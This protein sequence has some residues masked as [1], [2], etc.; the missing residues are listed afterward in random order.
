MSYANQLSAL[1][2]LFWGL[3]LGTIGAD[4]RAQPTERALT[5]AELGYPEGISLTGLAAAQDLFVPVPAGLQ[6]QALRLHIQPPPIPSEGYVRVTSGGRLGGQRVLPEAKTKI[7]IPMPGLR[8]T[9][10]GV[11]LTVQA[12]LRGRDR[13]EA[14]RFA[15][16]DLAA[17]S[18]V[19][20]RGTMRP[21]QEIAAFFPAH[22]DRATL[23][24]PDPVPEAAAQA[25]L[26]LAAY[27][28]RRYPARPPTLVIR[29]MPPALRH[30]PDSLALV[31]E[32]GPWARSIVWDPGAGARLIF[33]GESGRFPALLIGEDQ[34][35]RQLVR[36]PSGDRVAVTPALSVDTLALLAPPGVSDRQ[37]LAR[38]GATARTMRGVGTLSTAYPFAL[39]DFGPRR[40]PTGFHLRVR[41]S[42]LPE[43]GTA[44]VEV[45]LNG[46]V[47]GS[48][49]LG[50]AASTDLYASLPRTELQPANTLTVRVAYQAP[51]GNCSLEAQPISVTVDP[52]SSFTLADGEALPPGFGRAPQ[53]LLPSFHVLMDPRTVPALQQA[54]RLIGAMQA[55]TRRSLRPQ[56]TS[57]IPA[58]GPLLALGPADLAAEAQ[59]P[60]RTPGFRLIGAGGGVE[61]AF[62]PAHPYAAL[63]AFE[64]GRRYVLMASGAPE[65]RRALLDELLASDGWYGVRGDLA[66]RG[67]HGP[68]TT[69]RL[70][71]TDVRVEPLALDAPSFWTRYR[72]W[73]YLGAALLLLVVLAVLYPKVVRHGDV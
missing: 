20:L 10:G 42:A 51:S 14:E 50:R 26:D 6:V 57:A 9:D 25:A 60:V 4:V 1:A 24:V 40:Y 46:A 2:I 18:E 48:Q 59:A 37:P 44:S 19:V 49:R 5:F 53:A 65:A 61:M 54:A 55:T 41:H 3:C 38:M 39:A 27:L 16:V 70:H 71:G 66:L 43:A 34:A 56:I 31:P 52:R 11:P 63:Q 7:T 22:L 45:L 67:P 12:V 62:R 32:A 35:V 21:P 29:P 36:R 28:P 23:F 64:Q 17:E 13:C 47:V 33:D 72:L 15:R 68:A 8:P 73:I 58:S 69:V 30:H